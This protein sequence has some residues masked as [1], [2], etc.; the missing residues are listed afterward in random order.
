MLL[1]H[2]CNQITKK[3]QLSSITITLIF[4]KSISRRPRS[5]WGSLSDASAASKGI[6]SMVRTAQLYIVQR[7]RRHLISLTLMTKYSSWIFEDKRHETSIFSKQSFKM[8]WAGKILILT[9]ALVF[10]TD[11]STGVALTPFVYNSLFRQIPELDTFNEKGRCSLK[12]IWFDVLL[13][14]YVTSEGVMS[15]ECNIPEFQSPARCHGAC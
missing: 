7:E 4:L 14:V 3:N 15:W 1:N 5:P 12:F 10:M 9:L 13:L 6:T 2:L 11:G 8:V